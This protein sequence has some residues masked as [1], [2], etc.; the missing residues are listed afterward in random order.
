MERVREYTRTE[1]ELDER[2]VPLSTPDDASPYISCK[3]GKKY[4][5]NKT[6]AYH[7][8]KIED[9]GKVLK[10]DLCIGTRVICRSLLPTFVL[11]GTSQR[12]VRYSNAQKVGRYS[13]VVS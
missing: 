13:P 5:R 2:K 12:I 3:A 1:R 9:E 6:N 7:P 8:E 10:R 4:I 11:L